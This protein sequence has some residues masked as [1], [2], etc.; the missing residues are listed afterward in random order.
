MLSAVDINLY[1][2]QVPAGLDTNIP[3]GGGLLFEVYTPVE[4]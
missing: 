1:E 3:I 2:R 4:P